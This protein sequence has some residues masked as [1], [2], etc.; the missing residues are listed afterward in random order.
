MMIC[1]NE[2]TNAKPRPIEAMRLFLPLLSPFAPHLVEELW[3]HLATKFAGFEGLASQSAWPSW[4]EDYLVV[5]EVSYA[6]QVNGKVRGHLTVP[7][8]A[9]KESVEKAALAD[10]SLASQLEGKVIKKIIVVPGRL[11]NIVAV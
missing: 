5:S 8:A 1:T 7:I 4:N 10:A 11:V 2:F 3:S 6:L 9:G